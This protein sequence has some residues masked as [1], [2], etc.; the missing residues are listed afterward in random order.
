IPLYGHIGTLFGTTEFTGASAVTSGGETYYIPNTLK[1]FKDTG[2]ILSSKAFE[3][4]ALTTIEITDQVLYM[5]EE[6]LA[7]ANSLVNLTIPYVGNDKNATEPS[8]NT[9][10][11]VLFSKTTYGN[12]ITYGAHQ[13]YDSSHS[14]YYYLPHSLK[15]VTVNGG[16]FLGYEFSDCNE[17][18]KITLN[19][20]TNLANR[21][22]YHCSADV[23]LGEGLQT[24]GDHAF[25]YSNMD[26]E[27]VIPDSVTSIGEYAFS[28]ART[29][30]SFV[31]GKNVE[32]LGKS[33]FSN[34]EAATSITFKGTK[35]T[36]INAFTFDH[37][38]SL[39]TIAIPEGVTEIKGQ[40]FD[41]CLTLTSV[42]LPSTL[43][44][45][46]S[47]VFAHDN[48]LTTINYNG[49]KAQWNAITKANF[50][51]SSSNCPKLTTIHCTDGNITL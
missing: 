26:E 13:Q 24:I 50:W 43:N 45:M 2:G 46:A 16:S 41:Y 11:G 23:V 40:A 10:F 39:Q 27:L 1:N 35:I 42:S 20:V 8:F 48:E 25:Y 9:L 47:Y 30:K 31:V 17:L 44:K 3:G 14:T 5:N 18:E 21:S 6:A 51:Y 4:T 7:G 29:I 34:C 19:G 32:T 36:E 12:T 33:A 38:E 49:T 28:S 22:F 37:C 15:N